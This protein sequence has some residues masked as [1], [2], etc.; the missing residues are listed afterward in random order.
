[1]PISTTALIVVM[2][3]FALSAVVSAFAARSS[4]H[5]ELSNAGPWWGAIGVGL[6][7]ALGHSAIAP[8]AY[9]P[10][11][12]TDRLPILAL[13]AALVAAALAGGRDVLWARVL[14]LAGL[15]GLVIL[16][17]LGPVLGAGEY[18]E[19][20][21]IQ[22]ASISGACLLA[23]VNLALLD[24]PSSRLELSIGLVVLALGAAIVLIL[25]NSLVLCLLGG[26]LAAVLA[27][28]LV[29]GWG[30]PVGG[31]VPV[32]ATILSA[33]LVEGS[34]YAFLPAT[35]AILL[36]GSPG[37]LWL[38]RWGPCSRLG[39]KARAGLA[40]ALIAIPVGIAI[41]LTFFSRVEDA[42]GI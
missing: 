40:V 20:T 4:H 19:E 2:I 36:A 28:S 23:M 33:L 17:M 32:A 16:V 3:A 24:R 26:T 29:G 5:R 6:A 14:G 31:G 38:L 15:A 25:S 34:V 42:S 39:P 21:V 9:P 37:L 22:L 27:F 12:V 13:A 8:P 30:R 41:V 1:M 7:Y 18:S 35:P 10:S 11:D